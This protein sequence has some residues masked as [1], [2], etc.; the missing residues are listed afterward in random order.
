[1]FCRKKNECDPSKTSLEVRIRT[2]EIQIKELKEKLE[3]EYYTHWHYDYDILYTDGL[4]YTLDLNEVQKKGYKLVKTFN[5]GQK[6][7]WVK[8][9]NNTNPSPSNLGA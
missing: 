7:L 9:E 2:L 8:Y 6:Q 1:M 3:I 4:Y 5:N